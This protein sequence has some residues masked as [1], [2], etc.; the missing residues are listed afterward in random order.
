MIN[1]CWS[2]EHSPTSRD[3]LTRS[4]FRW[5]HF[6]VFKN[7]VQPTH[8][9]GTVINV[10]LPRKKIVLPSQVY[11]T[12]GVNSGF[13]HGGNRKHVKWLMR[14]KKK[15]KKTR[16][17][18]SACA[19]SRKYMLTPSLPVLLFYTWHTQSLQGT[20]NKHAHAKPSG[21]CF[22]NLRRE[23]SYTTPTVRIGH[24]PRGETMSDSAEPYSICLANVQFLKST[25]KCI[26]VE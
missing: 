18:L 14:C 7:R 17:N 3:Q 12:F 25:S 23:R 24:F 16:R 26:I 13:I 6:C 21:G 8:Q 5:H 11:P 2:D 9:G 19:D 4:I 22:R 15:T 20:W 10:N 1:F